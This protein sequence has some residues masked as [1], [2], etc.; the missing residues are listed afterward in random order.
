MSRAANRLSVTL[1]TLLAW[2]A[3]LCCSPF[4]SLHAEVE[5]TGVDK[6]LD[7]N[8]R[9]YMQLDDEPCDAPAWRVRRLYASATQEIQSALEVSGY[10]NATVESDFDTGGACWQAR[11]TIVPD[12]PVRL[13]QVLLSVDTGGA[14]DALFDKALA[15]CAL[16]PGDVFLHVNYETCKKRISRAADDHGYFS[17]KFT[18][19][20]VDVYP[21]KHAADIKLEYSSGPRYT[22][23]TINFEQEVLKDELAARFIEFRPGDPYDAER[24]RD[25]QLDLASSRYFDQINLSTVPRGEPYFDVLVLVGLTPGMARQFTYGVGYATD[26]GPRV[27]FEA[28]NRRRNDSGHQSSFQVSASEVLSEAVFTYRIPLRRPAADSFA[29]NTGYLIEETDTTSSDLFSLGVSLAHKRSNDWVRK[30]FV[31]LRLEDYT[32]GATDSGYSKLIVP[33]LNY[34]Y[35]TDDYPPRPLTGHR[36]E[37]YA[38]GATDAVVSDASFMQFYA[39]TKRIFGLW[40]GGRVLLRGEYGTTLID[41]LTTLPT[42]VRYFAG[43][44]VSVRGYAYK[45][46]GPEDEFG[47]VVGGKHVVTGSVELDQRFARNWSVAAF[48]DSGN[49]FDDYDD[50]N[51]ATGV[52]AGVRWYSIIGPIRFDVAVPLEANAPDD[53][54]IVITMGPDL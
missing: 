25:L 52:G 22:F 38:R 6:T 12:E 28:L 53:Y 7:E 49:A 48:V 14:P 44:D 23:G 41:G 36:T 19:Q 4:A 13:R 8:I 9:G 37:L 24:I 1:T 30:W 20:T 16:L 10:Y 43:G 3:L 35:A 11:F 21:D 32:A 27:R 18:Q 5:L 34:S 31:D 26:L 54:R 33:G 51:L 39:Q 17:G 45:E 42:S 15:E 2:A 40:Q 47:E 29:V 50:I 46:L